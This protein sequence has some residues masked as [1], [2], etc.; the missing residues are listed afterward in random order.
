MLKL[1]EYR[2]LIFLSIILGLAPF[3]P[4]PHLFEKLEM[5]VSGTLTKPIDIFDL[6]MHASPM[7]LLLV[8]YI[9]D[10]MGKRGE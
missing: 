4:A 1:F 2:M 10:R 6:I 5:L 3:L 7:V 9:Y 8:K